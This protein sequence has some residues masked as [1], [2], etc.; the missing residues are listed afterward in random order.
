MLFRKVLIVLSVM[1]YL[2]DSKL[3][4]DNSSVINSKNAQGDFSD[5]RVKVAYEHLKPVLNDPCFAHYKVVFGKEYYNKDSQPNL[6][7]DGFILKAERHSD[8]TDIKVIGKTDTGVAYGLFR[9]RRI[10]LH[11]P[12]TLDSLNLTLYP[13]YSRRVM[14]DEA[15]WDRE[16]DWDRYV[17]KLHSYLEEGVNVVDIWDVGSS[18]SAPKYVKD[19]SLQTKRLK[20]IQRLI[21]YAHSLGMKMYIVEGV[22][23]NPLTRAIEEKN[24]SDAISVAE[25]K[26]LV[27]VGHEN[28]TGW[29]E[30][31][32]LCMNKPKSI[33][34]LKESRQYLYS[35]LPELDGVVM[36]LGDP[37]GCACPVCSNWGEKTTDL[38]NNTYLS[39]IEKS[40]PGLD[41]V[42]SSWG[43]SY[44]HRDYLVEH[45]A[46]FGP[47]VQYFQMPPTAMVHGKYLMYEQ[48]QVDAMLKMSKS[49]NVINQQFFDGVGFKKG[50]VNLWEHPMP[51]EMHKSFRATK[52][53]VKGLYG[54]AFDVYWQYLDLRIMMEWAW[55]PDRDP[56]D[57]LAEFGDEH[58]GPGTGKFLPNAVMAMEDYWNNYYEQ[59]F[60]EAKN[61]D[62]VEKAY[63]LAKLIYE[64]LKAG[65]SYVKWDKDYYTVLQE[66]AEIMMLTSHQYCLRKNA[67]EM[68][69]KGDKKAAIELIEQAMAD[70]NSVTRIALAS[71]KTGMLKSNEWGTMYDLLKRP[72]LIRRE[73]LQYQGKMSWRKLDIP[74]SSLEEKLWNQ[75]GSSGVFA[76]SG[77]AHS[78]H[79]AAHIESLNGDSW[80]TLES[81]FLQLPSNAKVRVSFWYKTSHLNQD[82]F[83][84]FQSTGIDGINSA[85]QMT[86]TQQ[87]AKCH[88]ELSTPSQSKLENLRLRFVLIGQAPGVD[89]DD[90]ELEILEKK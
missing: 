82:L 59:F 52:D 40:H 11:A 34:I 64:Q 3:Q 86:T 55:Q 46:Q 85:A 37:G 32:L 8:V 14:Y 63:T 28:D 45:V 65:E 83:L 78:G 60:Y 53:F 77:D 81:P 39:L 68:F 73:L 69:A 87:W 25:I 90:V 62:D 79:T 88:V 41:V 12:E 50:H 30:N 9:L 58:F 54:S 29:M 26:T 72:E 10:M 16:N 19:N 24:L 2:F 61:F 7:D 6:P 4:A 49:R 76:W 71:K 42:I 21:N 23:Y 5:L 74:D 27:A 48:S 20:N 36:Y 33:E 56:A 1:L 38:I 31:F 84:D 17:R 75:T 35:A 57:T 51:R 15:S 70:A 67:K 18:I 44:E 22:N 47:Q 13:K 89:I 43:L 66:Q 80:Q